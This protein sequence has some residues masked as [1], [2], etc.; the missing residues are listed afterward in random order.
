MHVYLCRNSRMLFSGVLYG[1]FKE[2]FQANACSRSWGRLFTYLR[3]GY[4]NMEYVVECRLL[5]PPAWFNIIIWLALLS[6]VFSQLNFFFFWFSPFVQNIH[7]LPVCPWTDH[8]LGCLCW[9]CPNAWQ[10]PFLFLNPRNHLWTGFPALSYMFGADSIHLVMLDIIYA[11]RDL[12]DDPKVGI[13][14]MAVRF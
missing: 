11:H 1:L 8:H 14:S 4:P 5:P 3:L 7:G 2:G 9:V 10:S 6:T 13:Y 12:R